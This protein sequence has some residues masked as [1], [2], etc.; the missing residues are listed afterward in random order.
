M[1][2][3]LSPSGFELLDW[4][5][6]PEPTKVIMD[7]NYGKI[8]MQSTDEYWGQAMD[9][10]VASFCPVTIVVSEVPVKPP[11]IPIDFFQQLILNGEGSGVH[12]SKEVISAMLLRFSGGLADIFLNPQLQYALASKLPAAIANKA[13]NDPRMI[14]ASF[15]LV[16]KSMVNPVGGFVK[17]LNEGRMREYKKRLEATDISADLRRELL[18]LGDTY[19]RGSFEPFLFTREFSKMTEGVE[20]SQ[21]IDLG[22]IMLLLASN[23]SHNSAVAWGE[24]LTAIG[25]GF[26]TTATLI[27]R[28]LNNELKYAPLNVQVQGKAADDPISLEIPFFYPADTLGYRVE[29]IND[30]V[31]SLLRTTLHD[32]KTKQLIQ[33]HGGLTEDQVQQIVP[34]LLTAAMQ[35]GQA[36]QIILEGLFSIIA[37]QNSASVMY[38]LLDIVHQHS[39]LYIH[40]MKNPSE[41]DFLDRFKEAGRLLRYGLHRSVESGEETDFWSQI[42]AKIPKAFQTQST[43]ELFLKL[44]AP[45]VES[46]LKSMRRSEC[47]PIFGASAAINRFI[48]EEISKQ[49]NYFTD[50]FVLNEMLIK[51]IDLYWAE[52]PNYQR[53]PG[54]I[55]YQTQLK[56]L[57]ENVPDA[58]YQ[59]CKFAL[60]SLLNHWLSQAK[61][62][63]IPGVKNLIMATAL[64]LHG[65]CQNPAITKSL[66]FHLVERLAERMTE[67]SLSRQEQRQILSTPL[68][69]LF[70]NKFF[71]PRNMDKVLEIAML[72][73]E[74]GR[75]HLPE[76]TSMLGKGLL[77]VGAT[78]ASTL[79]E[80]I[81]GLLQRKAQKILDYSAGTLVETIVS[82]VE[83]TISHPDKG[84]KA[85]LDKMVT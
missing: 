42:L 33:S 80:W 66:L 14:A 17:W 73:V 15:D 11:V 7:E 46:Q 44:T 30:Q 70:A 84:L 75:Q 53:D 61:L 10:M 31:T 67:H 38:D 82:K 25:Q 27:T 13:R 72:L 65:A 23:T 37:Y 76:G 8:L 35:S 12:P 78:F 29:R 79:S 85:T 57:G 45:E 5:R 48:A 39:S 16:A 69:S 59:T 47:L 1:D 24:L 51:K 68:N 20:E 49:V 18:T 26:T 41:E 4:S 83:G 58:T 74:V 40:V 62:P 19:W 71:S 21:Q 64:E 54:W 81:K 50:P 22:R 36:I 6:S 9:N 52:V 3:A 34:L 43:L 55:K 28:Q 77:W 2:R 32:D 56:T 60:E 63:P